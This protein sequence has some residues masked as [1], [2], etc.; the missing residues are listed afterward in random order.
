MVTLTHETGSRS[1]ICLSMNGNRAVEFYNTMSTQTACISSWITSTSRIVT[2]FRTNISHTSAATFLK[3]LHHFVAMKNF[4]SRKTNKPKTVDA[5]RGQ[6][7]S[8][9]E[10]SNFIST[11]FMYDQNKLL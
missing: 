6:F 7:I 4:V 3:A 11:Y 10:R 5:D 2:E 1:L 9:N 8:G